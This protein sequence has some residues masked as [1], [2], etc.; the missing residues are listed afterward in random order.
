MVDQGLPTSTVNRRLSALRSFGRFLQESGLTRENPTDNLENV[1]NFGNSN[2]KLIE[3][4]QNSLEEPSVEAERI[5][6]D[7]LEFLDFWEKE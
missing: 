6:R 1:H 2:K 3:S 7:A 4:F 5:A